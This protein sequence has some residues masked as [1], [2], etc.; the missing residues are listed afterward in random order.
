LAPIILTAP[1]SVM[2][3][4]LFINF[5]HDN[6]MYIQNVMFPKRKGAGNQCFQEKSTSWWLVISR[7]LRSNYPFTV[8]PSSLRML[9]SF[10]LRVLPSMPLVWYGLSRYNS[11]YMRC[12]TRAGGAN[13]ARGYFCFPQ[14]TWSAPK[15]IQIASFLEFISH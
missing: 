5:A 8:I 11:L 9:V 13:I 7:C 4:P 6:G 3:D 2:P 1:C 10:K 15:K 14:A 12:R